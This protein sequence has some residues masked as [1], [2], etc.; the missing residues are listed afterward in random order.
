MVHTDFTL[1]NKITIKEVGIV[2][3]PNNLFEHQALEMTARI[4]KDSIYRF[5]R[6]ECIGSQ[7]LERHDLSLNRTTCNNEI[8][9]ISK[10]V[11]EDTDGLRYCVEPTPYGL[12]FAKGEITY[13]EYKQSQ[14]KETIQGLG[15]FFI[16][17]SAFVIIS[18]TLVWYLN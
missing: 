14:K 3:V 13:K 9:L 1:L 17:V 12:R 6:A 15:L 8:A 7:N 2:C 4:Q 5:I 10:I 16:T 18:W 11:L